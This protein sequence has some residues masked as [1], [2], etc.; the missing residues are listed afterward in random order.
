MTD[1]YSEKILIAKAKDVI[2]LCEKHY[3]PKCTDFLSPAQAAAIKRENLF[4]ADS[5]Q[6]FFG[7]YD[8]AER[9]MFI[10][11]P[12]Y[13]DESE[14]KE[15]V[16]VLKITA[17]DLSGLSHRDVLGSLLGL[18]IKREKLGDII[19]CDDEIFVFCTADMAEYINENLTK[20]SNKGIKTELKDSAEGL[21]F[22]QKTEEIRATVQ[23][24]RLDAV[25]A[26]A[27]RVSRS[28]A[29]AYIEGEKV[30]LNWQTAKS[31]SAAVKEGDMLSVRG[32]GRFKL[33]EA[34]GTTKKGRIAVTILKYV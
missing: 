34:G 18:G 9:V 23:S 8:E 3:S 30:N 4:S 13:A 26:A 15:L 29:L 7:G 11:L 10:S 25:L 31:G 1:N 28:K 27:L 22:K 2:R 20:I 14:A 6:M 24:L 17:R 16:G 32:F 21:V 12:D 33:F 5:K 19:F